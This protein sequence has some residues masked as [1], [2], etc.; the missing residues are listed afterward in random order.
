MS[1]R[2]ST[3]VPKYRKHKQSGQ[4]IVTLVDAVSGRRRDVLLGKFGTAASRADYGRAI[5]EWE[6]AG[7]RLAGAGPAPLDITINE[8]LVRFLEHAETHYRRPDGTPTEEVSHY[9]DAMRPLKALFGPTPAAEFGPLAL[10]AIQRHMVQADLSRPTINSRIGKLR[11][12]FKWATSEQLVPVA[13]HQALATVTG[14]Q[15]GRTEAKE[16]KPVRP[17]AETHVHA[18]LPHMPP[19]VAAL[20]RLQ[21][22]TGARPGELVIMR[23]ADLETSG[24]VWVYR[25]QQHKTQHHDKG[26]EVY[27]GPKAQE[28]VKP[29]LRT[30]LSEFIFSPREGEAARQAQRRKERKTPLWPSHVRHQRRKRK[31][32]RARGP[33]DRYTTNTYAKAIQRACDMAFPPPD[34]IAQREGESKR[35]WLERLT[36]EQRADLAAWRKAQRWHP[37]QL[38]HTAATMIRKEHGVELAR[39]ILGH[40]SAF[41]TEIYAEAD[42]RQAQDVMGKIG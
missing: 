38:R 7:R 37:H 19:A 2:R 16:P 26:R 22:L 5:S 4:A 27:L 18:S 42:R 39:I 11:R 20:V 3:S 31:A 23:T 41:T 12:I 32:R 17:V 25:P 8:L 33:T 21:L 40:A 28:V 14:L 35:A 24:R 34:A 36:P 29:W 6:A 10:K 9:R 30:N 13:V 1:G 15:R